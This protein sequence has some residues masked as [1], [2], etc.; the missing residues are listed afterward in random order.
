MT[1]GAMAAWQAWALILAAGALAA[2]LFLLKVRP[3][4]VEVASL[5]LWR[6]VLDQVREMT[7]WERVRKAVSLA[8]TMLVAA[9][10][11]VAVARPAPRAG[12]ASRGRLLIVLDSSWSMLARNASGETRW[13]RAAASARALALASGLDAVAVATTA[14]GLVE[15]PTSDTALIETAID[16]L[17]PTG[18]EGTA[19][20][21]IGGADAVHFFTDGSVPR[22]LP[23]GVVV[24]SVYEAAPNVAITALGVRP[25]ATGQTGAE[26][27]LEVAN[28]APEAQ[29][30]TVTVT[31]GTAV[32]FDQPVQMAAGEAIRQVIPL[33]GAGD[34]RVRAR[35]RAA[36]NSLDLD[37]EA[38][39]WL[40]QAERLRV[41]IVS[42]SPGPLALLLSRAPGIGASFA[43]PQQYTTGD[44]DVVI[45]DRWLPAEP[46]GRP[47]LVIAPAS[48]QPWLGALGPEERE[49]RW[50]SA[51]DHPVTGGVDP[52][53]LAIQRARPLAGPG[54]VPIAS[55]A[56]G[57]PLI[58]V[59]D[60]SD[61]RVVVWSFAGSD[62][63]LQN[64]TV[65]PVLVENSLEW[66]AR[67]AFDSPRR[68]GPV[69]L[70]A[71]V[72]RVITPDGQP[73]PLRTGGDHVVANLSAPG[74]FRVEGGGARSVIGVNVGSA[75]V[76]NLART[77]LSPEVA[78][79]GLGAPPAGRPWWMY[80]VMLAFGL[81]AVEW[82]TWL[83]RITV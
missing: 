54:L 25:A 77:H 46:P 52:M 22:M 30:V 75:E 80:A 51:G 14:D 31:R 69:V 44:E 7:W 57:T 17:V 18:G 45:F 36:A 79:A 37:D 26:A 39:G 66:L 60:S 6:K 23:E 13:A 11:A 64:S 27:Y 67:P 43:A 2:W 38:V 50:V 10:L 42:A 53:T 48:G 70:P 12:A 15:G 28:F 29:T 82:W 33:G 73:I 74:F 58:S 81:T 59:H 41:K 34:P 72:T 4:R 61:R 32:A 3:P 35:I 71:S 19:W 56:S 78:A 83:R 9:A 16:R 55:S 20:P 63:N 21:R 24:H 68:P 49:P 76:S 40:S 1:F 8:A 5:L 62:S 47:A 65:F